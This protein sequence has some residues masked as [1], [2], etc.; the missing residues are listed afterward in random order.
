MIKT[1]I[2][3]LLRDPSDPSHRL[4]IDTEVISRGT[5]LPFKAE[6]KSPSLTRPGMKEAFGAE[7][8]H[9]NLPSTQESFLAYKEEK[10][11]GG[12]DSLKEKLKE[13]HRQGLNH[14]KS[15][16]QSNRAMQ[17][18]NCQQRIRDQPVSSRSLS[19]SLSLSVSLFLSIFLSLS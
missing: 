15:A 9:Q 18:G 19:L 7:K 3:A 11:G 10:A 17:M 5:A 16:L 4:E 13:D 12:L 8:C 2:N 14:L 6:F 1:R